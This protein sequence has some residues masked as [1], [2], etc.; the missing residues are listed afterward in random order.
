LKVVPRPRSLSTREDP[1][2]AELVWQGASELEQ[3][4]GRADG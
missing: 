3:G 2:Y 4:Y 1:R